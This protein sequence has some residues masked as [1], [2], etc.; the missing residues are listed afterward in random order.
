MISRRS[1][2]LSIPLTGIFFI[3]KKLNA[4]PLHIAGLILRFFFS[5]A[6]RGAARNGLRLLSRKLIGRGG[7]ARYLKRKGSLGA[8]T[9]SRSSMLATA[10]HN[11]QKWTQEFVQMG[12]E[13]LVFSVLDIETAEANE[14]IRIPKNAPVYELDNQDSSFIEIEVENRLNELQVAEITLYLFD[15]DA[16]L[17]DTRYPFIFASVKAMGTQK[18]KVDLKPLKYQGRKVIVVKQEGFEGRIS[19]VIYFV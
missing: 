3:G 11:E 14:D 4:T 5:F 12:L 17:V 1:L 16:G 13:E 18:Y 15:V 9:V 6:V 10:P 8:R 2:L 19:P 7:R